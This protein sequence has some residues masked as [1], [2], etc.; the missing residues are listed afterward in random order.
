M[1]S[2]SRILS[3]LS[4]KGSWSGLASQMPAIT[5]CQIQV[6]T[7]VLRLSLHLIP[8]SRTGVEAGNYRK[9]VVAVND[10]AAESY[11][12]KRMAGDTNDRKVFI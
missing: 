9:T 3:L 7:L 5:A 11:G 4:A 2:L 1:I 12:E 8:T 10:I 6:M